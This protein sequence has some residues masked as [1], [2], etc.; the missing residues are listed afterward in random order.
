MDPNEQTNDNAASRTQSEIAD[1]LIQRNV[2][3]RN[4]I[5]LRL[6]DNAYQLRKTRDE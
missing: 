4:E 2:D 1:S 6:V 5:M 3:W